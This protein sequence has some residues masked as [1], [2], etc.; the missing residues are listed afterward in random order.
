MVAAENRTEQRTPLEGS[1]LK[2]A[3]EH[4]VPTYANANRYLQLSFLEISMFH[5]VAC[6]FPRTHGGI[7]I[8][9]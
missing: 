9:K 5:C 1:W 2:K 4:S 8:K 6:L 7:A 3:Y